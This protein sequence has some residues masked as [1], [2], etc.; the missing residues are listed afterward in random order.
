MNAWRRDWGSTPLRAS[1]K[2][3]GQIGGRGAR[4]HVARVLLVAGRVR[5]DELS[6]GRGEVAIR[7][8]D[9]DA[10]FPLRAQSVG[11]QREIDGAGR[12]IRPSPS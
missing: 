10:L 4:R 8:I 2:N 5:D 9:R 11:Q 7:D 12:L 3:D 6:P 1:I